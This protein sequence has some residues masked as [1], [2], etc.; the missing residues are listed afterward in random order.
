MTVK[1][2]RDRQLGLSLKSFVLC[3]L[4]LCGWL[5][6]AESQIVTITKGGTYAGYGFAYSGVGIASETTEFVIIELS[7]VGAHYTILTWLTDST[8]LELCNHKGLSPLLRA[9]KP[10]L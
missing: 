4:L 6:S 2:G 7:T 1:P 3:L 5:C 8:I 10:T 9:R